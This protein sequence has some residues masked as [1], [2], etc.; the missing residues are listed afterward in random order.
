MSIEEKAKRLLVSGSEMEA[1]KGFLDNTPSDLMEQLDQMALESGRNATYALL[2]D[3]ELRYSVN[4]NPLFVWEAI[5]LCVSVNI[6]FPDWVLRYLLDVSEFLS[7][8]QT[9][10]VASDQSQLRTRIVH[11]F[12]MSLPQGNVFTQ[13]DRDNE[14]VDVK[15]AINDRDEVGMTVQQMCEAFGEEYHVEPETIL[16]RYYRYKFKAGRP[17]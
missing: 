15:I 13:R 1:F 11:A 14:V 4:N 3:I 2:M 9:D 5:P 16:R 8:I 6:P 12:R 17:D 7:Q 10:D